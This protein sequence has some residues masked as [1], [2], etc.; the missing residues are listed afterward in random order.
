MLAALVAAVVLEALESGAELELQGDF[1]DELQMRWGDE[2]LPE[3]V[4]GWTG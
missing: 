2:V 1:E 3:K 4:V